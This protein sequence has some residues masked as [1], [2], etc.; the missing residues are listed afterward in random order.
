MF[1]WPPPITRE[2][3]FIN[4]LKYNSILVAQLLGRSFPN[5]AGLK[6]ETRLRADQFYLKNCPK[7]IIKS[8]PIN[9][10]FKLKSA[11]M[12]PKTP[13]LG[14]GPGYYLTKIKRCYIIIIDT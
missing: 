5:R 9:P 2:A 7:M 13:L 4:F 12:G 11:F 14:G 3:K 10:L 6:S 8:G 1:L